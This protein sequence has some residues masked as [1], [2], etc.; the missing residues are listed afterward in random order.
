MADT[1]DAQAYFDYGVRRFDDDPEA[2]AA[3]FYWSARINP[4]S[5]DAWYARRAAL[6][7]TD[8]GL[9]VSSAIRRA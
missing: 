9:L 7:M 6:L 1:N 5:A 3:A 8:E 2:A 4:G